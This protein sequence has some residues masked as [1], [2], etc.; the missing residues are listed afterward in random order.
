[1]TLTE[2]V[3]HPAYVPR[4]LDLRELR[5]DLY[6][7]RE[8]HG[9]GSWEAHDAYQRLN[10]ASH[11]LGRPLDGLVTRSPNE[12]ER[13]FAWTIPGP[14]AHI[15]W[16][17][18]AKFVRND[19]KGRKPIIW[20]WDHEGRPRQEG[21]SVGP[22]CGDA[23][24]INPDHALVEDRTQSKRRYTDDQ[25]IGA[26]QAAHLRFGRT[27]DVRAWEA[28]KLKPVY[29]V[30][31][32][33]FGSWERAWAA[34]GIVHKTHEHDV[35][36]AGKCVEVLRL[37]HRELGWWPTTQQWDRNARLRE[38]LRAHPSLP[39]SRTTII[40]RLG[41]WHEALRKAGRRA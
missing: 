2:H 12:V 27:L 25:I 22:T 40:R 35:V 29:E 23:A 36:S 6:A 24:C 33:R 39:S 26:L 5:N 20:W 18:P 31:S 16:T 13:F 38:I 4:T 19:G 21:A 41:P 9:R 34:A 37:V 32:R 28:L 7:A 1:M 3:P 10:Q 15:Y 30:A 14:D 8:T 17:G 11:M